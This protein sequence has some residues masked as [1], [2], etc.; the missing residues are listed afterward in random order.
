MSIVL[1]P[2]VIKKL[3]GEEEEPNP[4]GPFGIVV[5]RL[6]DNHITVQP[7]LISGKGLSVV[8]SPEEAGELAKKLLIDALTMTPVNSEQTTAFWEKELERIEHEKKTT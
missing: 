8:H 3:S 4:D 1:D 2:R 5:A 6:P 7:V